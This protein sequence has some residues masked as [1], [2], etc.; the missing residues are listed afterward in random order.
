MHLLLKSEKAKGNLSL[1][2]AKNQIYIR[3]LIYSK[4]E[5]FGV[6]IG[7]FV[8]MGNHLH[9]KVRTATRE[10]FQSFLK[11][12]TCLIARFVTGARRG[13]KFGR[14]WQGLAFTRVLTSS[15][16]ELRLRG[17][18]S[19]NRTEQ[20]AGR[21]KREEFL[22]EFNA[23]ARADRFRAKSKEPPREGYSFEDGAQRAWL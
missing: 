13:K 18:F 11:A 15:L 3:Q 10:Q 1:L 7:D 22:K 16:E 8:N 17:Y 5:H 4:G 2:S 12:I 23:W 21:A 14:F 6:L 9:I 20:V 19:A